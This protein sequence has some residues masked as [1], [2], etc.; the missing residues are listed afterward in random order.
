[1]ATNN[2]QSSTGVQWHY[3]LISLTLAFLKRPSALNTLCDQLGLLG[4]RDI[5][6]P[7]NSR[8]CGTHRHGALTM[9]RAFK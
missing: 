6:M 8:K 2:N 9:R 1:M 7:C 4:W 3:E 5:I